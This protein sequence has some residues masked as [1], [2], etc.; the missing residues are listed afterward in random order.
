MHFECTE[1]QSEY[2]EDEVASECE[3]EEEVTSYYHQATT[4]SKSVVE[5]STGYGETFS[6]DSMYVILNDTAT[7][8]T[9]KSLLKQFDLL[10]HKLV[11]VCADS[12]TD[13]D[14]TWDL[15]L[16]SAS[17][18]KSCG[19]NIAYVFYGAADWPCTKQNLTQ[20]CP[21]C[22]NLK[23]QEE[24][25]VRLKGDLDLNAEIYL[26]SFELTLKSKV[27]LV[28]D[29]HQADK[30]A[31][32]EETS[33]GM[34]QNADDGYEFEWELRNS[35]NP[36][37]S[38]TIITKN[39][40]E[41]FLSLASSSQRLPMAII[42]GTYSEDY[43]DDGIGKE[44][45]FAN[46]LFLYHSWFSPSSYS[47]SVNLTLLASLSGETL[48]LN[49]LQKIGDTTTRQKLYQKQLDKTPILSHLG[50]LSSSPLT[51]LDSWDTTIKLK[52][53]KTYTVIKYSPDSVSIPPLVV[54]ELPAFSQILQ[55]TAS[56]SQDNRTLNFDEQICE[57]VEWLRR[58]GDEELRH[59]L[60][61]IFDPMTL[62]I[63]NK[64]Q[65]KPINESRDFDR[66]KGKCIVV[67]CFAQLATSLKNWDATKN[68]CGEIPVSDQNT[69]VNSYIFLD[70]DVLDKSKKDFK[71]EVYD[72]LMEA[73]LK[74]KVVQFPELTTD[75]AQTMT[76]S[77]A[78]IATS[79]ES[80]SK[81]SVSNDSDSNV[82]K[83]SIKE[84]PSGQ[85][86]NNGDG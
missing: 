39:T 66:T 20:E 6:V 40:L 51:F 29:Q 35:F 2:E 75:D 83:V 48:C 8:E 50:T 82:V 22:I 28:Q 53:S 81:S 38:L 1:R 7:S 27:S 41:W 4:K 70:G 58:Q 76:N 21:P 74:H 57:S 15:L 84:K 12:V 61:V 72:S 71:K 69:C 65:A 59:P 52:C 26:G 10:S 49:F 63:N 34:S 24:D 55:F 79:C 68:I 3:T 80:Q 62:L 37:F 23:C 5:R 43:E 13:A 73:F 78:T 18:A 54:N 60:Y 17:K 9:V 45:Y 33:S 14:K 31:E 16:K 42:L 46:S 25:L 56:R 77:A 30:D 11:F 36:A 44:K 85:N 86:N 47:D 64:T 67:G 32:N 19:L